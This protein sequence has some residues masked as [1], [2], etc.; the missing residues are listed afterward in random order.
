MASR[1]PLGKFVLHV[2]FETRADGGLKA[3][4]EK[5]PN[6]FLSHSDPELVR[7]D[8]EPA[9]A[10]ILSEMYGVAMKVE[11]LPEM[12]EALTSQIPMSAHIVNQESYLG[13]TEAH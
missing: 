13:I 8:I 10:K 7:A 9:L 6:F 4:C 2:H 11:R 5:V 1:A 3:Y 12:E